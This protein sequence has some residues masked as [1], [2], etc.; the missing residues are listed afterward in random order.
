LIA[1][2]KQPVRFRQVTH[3]EK[4]KN[5]R[6][7]GH[8]EKREIDKAQEVEIKLVFD[9]LKVVEAI[10]MENIHRGFKAH[11]THLFTVQK[12]L[13]NGK[14]DKYKSRLV[15]HSNEQDTTLYSDRSSPKASVHSIM[16]C[17]AIA[18]C[19]TDCIVDKLVVKGAFIQTEMSGTPVYVQCRG[20]LNVMIL[21]V[22]P[23]LM[24]YVGSDGILY[25]KLLE[26]L[27]GCGQASH[28][29]YENLRKVL[30][31]MGNAQSETD[32]CIF[33]RIVGDRVFL[34][35]V[36]VEDILILATEDESKHLETCFLDEFR[37]ITLEIGTSHII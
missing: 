2:A 25:G 36:Y 37:W 6:E 31:G 34:L 4:L 15:A 13:A 19:N 14:H 1:G 11:N 8:S 5:S 29:W 17:L 16:T 32:A 26:A 20:K 9:D 21:R 33:C 18:A 28:L 3:T 7:K 27:Y 35:N 12:F 24:A 30:I 22:K 23:E 10:K